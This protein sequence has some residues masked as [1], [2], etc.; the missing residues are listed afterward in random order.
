M[1]RG[2]QVF[3]AVLIVILVAGAAQAQKADGIDFERFKP[4]MDMQGVILT[5]GGQGELAG[6][7]N[8]GMYMHYSQN[9]LEV[10]GTDRTAVGAPE[11]FDVVD[12][13][14]VG[15][16]YGSV[17]ITDWLAFGVDVPAVLYQ[18]G[19]EVLDR[20][21]GAPLWKLGSFA[22]ADIRVAPKVTMLRQRSHGISMALLVPVSLPSGD[23][24]DFAG[25]KGDS[26]T[27][28][29]TLAVSGT[30]ADD[31]VL[32]AFNVGAWLR[33]KEQYPTYINS[34][35]LQQY[36]LE[37]GHEL[38]A[39][40]GFSYSFADNWWAMAEVSAA[41]KIDNMF[42]EKKQT[43]LEGLVGIRLWGPGDVVFTLGGGAGFIKGWGTPDFRAFFGA[44]FSPRVHDR[45]KDGIDDKRDKCPD[46]PGPR[47]NDGCPWLD[48][49]GDGITDNLDKC[50]KEKGPKE[51]NG[52]PWGDRDGD[53]L[54][55]NVDKC[56]AEV[57]PKENNGCP[58][59]DVD[60]DGVSD[61][62]DKCPKQPGPKDNGGCPYG[63][64][65]GDGITDDKDKCPKKAG[66]GENNGCPFGDEDG[67]GVKDADDKCPKDAGPPEN[68]GC[69][70]GDTDG[71]G[72]KDNLDKC[73]KEPGPQ[74]NAGCPWGDKDGDGVLDNEDK[75][76]D[77]AGP[78]DSPEGKGCPKKYTLIKI[79]REKKKIEI[80]QKVHFAYARSRIK[81]DSFELLNQVAQAI[82][83][84]PDIQ[85]VRIEGHTDSRGSEK[86]NQRLSERRANSVMQYLLGKGVD[87][88]RLQAVGY[89][90]SK[91]IAP[92][93][94]DK[95]REANRRVEFVIVESD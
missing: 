72:V 76:P 39:R 45:D 5:E 89:G 54:K 12:T 8:L 20:N 30:L 42:A 52:C 1:T 4:S 86:Y 93:S 56:P 36:S 85:K 3:L 51:N 23:Q 79:D 11:T 80:K 7:F 91:P 63:D 57:G 9:P 15:H 87:P 68:D 74:E 77:K 27:A 40:L 34:P 59:G 19:T 75:C 81:G 44:S 33:S 41:A 64:T 26:V 69:P 70:W 82:N 14:L 37:T 88:K 92:N 55:D 84:N 38:F 95:G 60:G 49:D 53:G 90:E 28:S 94:T 31:T 50:P 13:R 61:N 48:T 18:D 2:C 58:Y 35:D 65:D 25:A 47:E 62:V 43:P 17:G 10:I 78:A 67:D 29:P 6:D 24:H 73:P 66:P 16:L 83:D 22:M 32:L 21:T 71:D 46:K